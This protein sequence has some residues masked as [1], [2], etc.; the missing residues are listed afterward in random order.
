M[1]ILTVIPCTPIY[2]KIEEKYA[3]IRTKR[4]AVPTLFAE[5][6]NSL[7][8][9]LTKIII[10]HVLNPSQHTVYILDTFYTLNAAIVIREAFDERR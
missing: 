4:A 3:I 1:N 9:W 2:I 8:L 10:Q 5:R 6:E 7:I